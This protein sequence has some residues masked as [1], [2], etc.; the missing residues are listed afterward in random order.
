VCVTQNTKVSKGL[1][2]EM[3]KKQ[4]S[5]KKTKDTNIIIREIISPSLCGDT[6]AKDPSRQFIRFIPKLKYSCLLLY[7]NFLSYYFKILIIM[8]CQCK[9]ILHMQLINVI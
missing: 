5:D 3:V 6:T 4:Q 7:F 2:E 9:V 1:L 8:H